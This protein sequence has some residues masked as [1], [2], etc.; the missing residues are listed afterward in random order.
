[1]R[2]LVPF[3]APVVFHGD[4]EPTIGIYG[5]EGSKPGAAA[6][7]VYLSHRVIRPSK[8]GYAKIIGQAVYSCKRLYTRLICMAGSTDACT[9]SPVPRLRVE[10][11]LPGNDPEEKIAYL[12]EHIDRRTNDEISDDLLL[13]D[14]LLLSR[15]T[16]PSGNRSHLMATVSE[17]FAS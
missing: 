6:A 14:R 1:M 15:F 9:V 4:A 17:P 11:Q 7:A 10:S 13:I 8:S 5:I 16:R 12:R 2:D 3:S